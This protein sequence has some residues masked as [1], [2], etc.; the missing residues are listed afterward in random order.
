MGATAVEARVLPADVTLPLEVRVHGRGGQGGVTCAKII[1]SIYAEQGL[2]VQ[3]FGDYGSE[4][5][6]APIRAFTRV[7]TAPI[8]NRNKVYAPHH[9]VVLDAGLLGPDVLDGAEAGTVVLL[10]TARGLA[11]FAGRHG[12]FRFAAVDATAIA[13]RHG[14]GTSAVVIINTTLAGAYARAMGLPW[15]AVERAFAAQGLAS[16]LPAAR[17]AW[18]AVE[19]RE[20]DAG[21]PPPEVG[22]RIAPQPVLGIAEHVADLPT[23]LRTGAWRTQVPRYRSHAA[24]CSAACPAGN[25]VLGFVRALETG[26]LEAAAGILSRTQPLPSVCGRV[27]PAPCMTACNRGAYDGAVNVRALERWIG[28]HAAHRPARPAPAERRRRV[29]VVGSGPAGL[30]AAFALATAGHEVTLHEGEDRLGGVLRTGIPEYRLPPE[31]LDRDVDRILS[32][33][34]TARTG[35]FLDADGVARLAA[36]NDAVIVAAGLPRLTALD[37]PGV[38]LDGVRQGIR[39]LD[40]VRK[41]EAPRLSGHVVVV[42]GGNT[43]IDCARTAL[44]LGA[45]AVSIAY[46]RGRKEMPAIAPEIDEAVEEG[47]RLLLHRQ[48]VRIAGEGRVEGIELAEVELGEPDAS[49]RRRPV[50]TDRT[51]LVPC[52]AVLLALGQSA[53]RSIVPDLPNVLLAGDMATGEG[54]VTHAIG[55]GRRAAARVLAA[56]DGAP[57][58]VRARPAPE[59]LVTPAHVRFSHFEVEPPHRERHRKGSPA[60]LGFDE[61][62]RG[63]DGPEEARRCFSCGTCTE[64]DTCVLYCPEGVVSRALHGYRIDDDFCKG[65]GMCV[66]ECPRRA[67]EMVVEARA[68]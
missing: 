33:G 1:A 29:A 15:D 57:Q 35:A 65:C 13:R 24:P 23:P 28:D 55:D 45:S 61:V 27:C 64:C 34:V 4:R 8:K 6:G 63:L 39:F 47:V 2:H 32:L 68:R 30:S 60:A 31:V 50:V 44:R 22:A 53:D 43:A 16:D 12:H 42:G 59:E 38:E 48:P 40:A 5:T 21:A 41:G 49:G 36:Q 51:A 37:A 66:A 11:P 14:I 46:R 10:N 62:N 17:E 52:D 58:P 20:A 9:V 67:M 25:D 56:L 19:I 26:G 54:T 3:T 7:D 18:D